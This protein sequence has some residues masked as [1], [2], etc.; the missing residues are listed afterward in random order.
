MARQTKELHCS[1]E[2]LG[3]SRKVRRWSYSAVELK[4]K[5]QAMPMTRVQE[6]RR[7]LEYQKWKERKWEW[8]WVL[9]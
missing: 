2:G 4:K 1:K 9:G 7:E 3:S 5:G 8:K 6:K